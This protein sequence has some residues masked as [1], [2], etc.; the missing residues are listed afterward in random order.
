MELHF[1]NR[2][3]WRKWLG[4]N[5]SSVDGFWMVNYKKHT[6]KECITYDDAVG[7][8]LCFGWIDGKIK[9]INDEYF[10]RWFTPRRTG[11]RWSKYNIERIERLIKDGKV[12]QAG[13]DAYQEALKRP[14]LMYDI[15]SSGDPEIPDDLLQAMKGDVMAFDNFVKFPP[16]ARRTYIDWLN[17]AKKAETRSGRI[18]KITEASRQNRRPGMM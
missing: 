18:L 1:K 6:K 2:K 13:L 4:K 17:Y 7:E 5:S 9:R 10:V 3:D 16:S 11:S 14:H 12:T 8:A 15:R